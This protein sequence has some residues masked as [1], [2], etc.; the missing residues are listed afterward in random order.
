MPVEILRSDYMSENGKTKKQTIQS[1]NHIGGDNAGRDVIKNIFHQ[2]FTINQY[3]LRCPQNYD[4]LVEH[5]KVVMG[6]D[7]TIIRAVILEE[8]SPIY[9]EQT[10][11]TSVILLEAVK[12]SEADI[13]NFKL[14]S[15][16][17]NVSD[18]IPMAE[19][20]KFIEDSLG[21]AEFHLRKHDFR[22]AHKIFENTIEEIRPTNKLYRHIYKEFLSTGFIYYSQQ[23]NIKGLRGL[24]EKKGAREKVSDPETDGLISN[25]FQEIC[26]R[27][28]D[29]DGIGN[30]VATITKIYHDAPSYIKPMMAKSLG[31]AYR[32][33]GERTG[34]SDLEKAIF[35][36]LEGL[37]LNSD[38]VIVNVE[39]KDQM[40][41]THVRIFEFDHDSNQLDTAEKLLDECVSALNSQEKI[42]P[43]NF[44]LLPRVLNNLGNVHK[45]RL[46]ILKS[47]ASASKAISCYQEGELYWTEP[48]SPYEW[49]ILRKNIAETKYAL[50][51][52]TN[53]V[54][55]L[56]Q[57]LSDGIIS[58]K[59]R[60]FE[61]S[62]YQW[63]KSVDIIFKIVIWVGH[64]NATKRIS[65]SER[66][67]LLSYVNTAV[68]NQTKWK[69]LV[70]NKFVQNALEAKE[71]LSPSKGYSLF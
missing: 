21:A 30:A 67:E 10:L 34:I 51:K 70:L 40:A 27:D 20:Q 37:A 68:K 43:K 3:H 12:K 17:D 46:L 44:R 15:N 7:E 41:I 18:D 63:A 29:L 54:E 13:S 52:L 1:E 61:N 49:A 16:H 31:L 58:T 62:S 42:D 28:T 50:S 19:N 47:I 11:R 32:R 56:M 38:D 71:V 59:Y 45:Q 9:N 25:I 4:E 33:L 60:N 23:N 22:K 57:A 5:L 14:I 35:Y 26:S 48:A 24:L 55:I 64:L 8:H 39:L 69:D 65:K 66:K 53:D 2:N 36:F 6:Y